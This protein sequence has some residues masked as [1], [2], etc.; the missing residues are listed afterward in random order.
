MKDFVRV[1]VAVP[2][3]KVGDCHNN[4]VEII[5]IMREAAEKQVKVIAFPELAITGYTC[6]DMF[7]QDSLIDASEAA[8]DMILK[9]TADLDLFAAIGM[10][11]RCDNR[12]FNGAVCICKS[13][14]LGAVLKTFLSDGE[15]RLFSSVSQICSKQAKICGKDVPVGADIIFKNTG[16]NGIDF[17]V[18]I[19]ICADVWNIIPPSSYLAINGAEIILNLAA[20]NELVYKDDYRRNLIAQQSGR[21]TGAYA[22][23]S[24]GWGESTTDM[25][26]SGHSLICENG[27][28]LKETEKFK[29]ESQLIYCDC[30][31]AKIKSER[32]RINLSLQKKEL[33]EYRSITF[34]LNTEL[35][36]LERKIN[37]HP[38]IP[39]ESEHA[40]RCEDIFNIQVAGLAKRIEHFNTKKAVLAISGGLDST[41]A[42]LVTVRAFDWLNKDRK[43]IVGITM[44]GFGTTGRTHNNAVDLMRILGIDSREIPIVEASLLH[45]RDIG[46]DPEIKD[47]TYENVQA[48]ER[49]QILMDVANKE[50]GMVIGTGDL[51]ELA[52]GWC[53]YNGDHMSMYGVN[54]GVPKTLVRVMIGY[55][56]DTI[57][58][59]GDVLRD[60]LDTPVS[61]ELL[62]A[63]K[64]GEIEQKTEEI[65][66][67]YE[68]HDFF[69]YY[70]IRFGFSPKKI[71]Y[72]AKYAFEGKYSKDEIKK[73][74]MVFYKRFFS[75]QFK[76]SCSPDGPKVGTVGLSPRGDLQMPSDMCAEV[77]L[78][79][80]EEI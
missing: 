69:L 73:W 22:Y 9:E 44:P 37:P 10:A 57:P 20:S 65:N 39:E 24:A 45:F 67:P 17:V 68:L 7:M 62:P 64:D 31:I 35:S 36:C 43:D 25:V 59:I 61:P 1:S 42:L 18:G 56:A 55:L 29:R 12:L 71:A 26:F 21:I 11:V 13:K 52:L 76:R 53:T 30:D 19:E 70:M 78:R 27:V 66:G 33:P 41:L 48:R 40:K 6:G 34:N 79:E 54:C 23:A 60:I 38:F 5:K 74:L 32:K 3:H 8:L 4:A 49:T 16:S 28:I 58:E 2:V 47:T 15:E 63:D 75:Q 77:W 46:H 51:S 80:V 50:G 14:I 72:L